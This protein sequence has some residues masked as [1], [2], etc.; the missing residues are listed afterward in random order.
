[1]KSSIYDKFQLENKIETNENLQI[2]KI[3]GIENKPK[4]LFGTNKGWNKKTT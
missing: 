2:D 1:M 4:I 3:K